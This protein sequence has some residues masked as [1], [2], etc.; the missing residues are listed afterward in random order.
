VLSSY[1][2]FIDSTALPAVEATARTMP[3][4]SMRFLGAQV[5]DKKPSC[6][7]SCKPVRRSHK[8]WL[9]FEQLG[10]H[11]LKV[12]KRSSQLLE[13]PHLECCSV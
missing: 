5:C 13:L 12:Y 7:S 6:Q 4:G 9:L 1:G 8:C 2:R 10:D 3:F 11:T